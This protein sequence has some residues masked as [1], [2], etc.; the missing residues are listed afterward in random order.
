MEEDMPEIQPNV[1]TDQELINY[2][3]Q[4]LGMNFSLPLEYQQELLKRYE[5]TSFEESQ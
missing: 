1:L 2:C 4:L 5:K 3:Y